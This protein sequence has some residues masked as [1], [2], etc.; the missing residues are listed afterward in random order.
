M[1]PAIATLRRATRPLRRR[2][3]AIGIYSASYD[4]SA[5]LATHLSCIARNTR[6]PFDYYLMKNFTTRAEGEAFDR[7]VRPFPFVKVFGGL[8]GSLPCPMRHGDSLQ[9]MVD[10]TDNEI[11]VLCDIDAYLI[12]DGWDRFVTEALES[13]TLVAV[14]ACF[15]E[16][17]G[18]GQFPVVGHPSFMAFKRSLLEDNGLDLYEGEGNDPAYKITRYLADRGWFNAEHV[19]ALLPESV[20]VPNGTFEADVFGV[21]VAGTASHG[22]C[23][24]Y[25]DFLFHFWHS[26]NYAQRQPIMGHDG[27]MLVSYDDLRQRVDDY[28]RRFGRSA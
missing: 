1:L 23:T 19:V 4:S 7:I 12:A 22:F 8:L 17:N 13:K 3:P 24:R 20:E 26:M 5:Y 28:N 6:G 16:R 15:R 21:G 18:V 27:R 25:G 14:I 10:R 11:I 9:L 2:R